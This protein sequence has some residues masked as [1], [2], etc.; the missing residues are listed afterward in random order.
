MPS[1]K[2]Q[3]NLSHPQLLFNAFNLLLRTN[4][5]LLSLSNPLLQGLPVLQVPFITLLNLLPPKHDFPI[6]FLLIIHINDIIM[7]QPLNGILAILI[8]DDIQLQSRE[9]HILI[10]NPLIQRIPKR[11]QMNRFIDHSRRLLSLILIFFKRKRYQLVMLISIQ[12]Y[13][14]TEEHL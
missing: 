12:L 6:N 11:R 7:Q 13:L 2:I 5:Y 10:I 4:L 3:Q 1:F 14:S 8:I 9:L